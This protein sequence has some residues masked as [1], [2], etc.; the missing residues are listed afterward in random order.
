MNKIAA[1]EV[2]VVVR[3]SRRPSIGGDAVEVQS[4]RIGLEGDLPPENADDCAAIR[5][6]PTI[7]MKRRSI[8]IMMKLPD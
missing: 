7:A 1:K 4:L 5:S 6:E 8:M 2:A 3:K